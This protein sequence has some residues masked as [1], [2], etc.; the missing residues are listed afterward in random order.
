MTFS[1]AA[2]KT[3]SRPIFRIDLWVGRIVRLIAKELGHRRAIN[4]LSVLSDHQLADIGLSRSDLTRD[5]LLSACALR[6][7]LHRERDHVSR[8][9]P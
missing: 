3:Q 9:T 4:D 8:S 1:D 5:G 7:A 2:P 6:E